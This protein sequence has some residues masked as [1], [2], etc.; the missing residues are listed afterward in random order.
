VLWN[1]HH[2]Y[3]LRTV[4]S[5]AFAADQF[6]A[7]QCFFYHSGSFGI[8][9]G[10]DGVFLAC[11]NTAKIIAISLAP[12]TAAANMEEGLAKSALNTNQNHDE[13]S[14]LC[15]QRSLVVVKAVWASGCLRY[16]IQIFIDQAVS[17]QDVIFR[18]HAI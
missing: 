8:F 16:P 14:A 4:E 3:F 10:P 7:R 9:F 11:Q 5:P 17:V 2:P 12:I 18:N 13:T 1:Q 6:S 15:K